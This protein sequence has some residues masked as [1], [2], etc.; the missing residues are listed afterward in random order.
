MRAQIIEDFGGTEAFKLT[1]MPDPTPAPGEVVVALAATSVNPVDY[2][3]RRHGPSIAPAL[4]AV[5]GCDVAGTVAAVGAGVTG[6]EVGDEVYGC[7][8]GVAGVSGGSYAERI[9]A[10]AR[11]LARK[12]ASLTLRQAAALPLV[13]ITAWEG[14]ERAG[15]GAGTSLLIHGGTG[16]VGHVAIQLAKARGATVST[17]VSSAAKAAVATSLG[18]D[19]VINYR[20]ER[21]SDYVA[22]L[23]SGQG[24]DVV[25]D[26]TGG[27]E[28]A[29]SFAA[30]RLNGAV[31]TIVSQ[32]QADLSPMHL[33]GLSLHVVFMLIPMLHDVGR[34]AHGRV[35]REAAVLADAGKLR[36]LIDPERFALED[37]PR[38]HARAEAGQALGKIVIDIAGLPPTG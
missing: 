21:V 17:T 36:P 11:L 6:L 4:P 3:I 27:D 23:T 20:E 34:E 35:L 22:R 10:D 26:A 5:L 2:K 29:T 37:L 24:F 25:F 12:P 18:A 13:T 30:A 33:K 28:I 8:G 32:Y 38:A 7:A 9:A 31:V 19:H 15:V 1:S 16:G 14:L